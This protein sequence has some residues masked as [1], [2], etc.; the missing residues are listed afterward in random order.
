M[1]ANGSDWLTVRF[2]RVHL[3]KYVTCIDGKTG[4]FLILRGDSLS[5]NNLNSAV[6]LA[7]EMID[8]KKFLKVVEKRLLREPPMYQ[9]CRAAVFHTHSLWVLPKGGIAT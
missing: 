4:V 7:S 1:C 5:M 8:F 3:C 6:P 2:V 9:S